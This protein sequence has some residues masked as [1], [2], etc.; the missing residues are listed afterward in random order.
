MISRATARSRDQWRSLV[1]EHEGK[2]QTSGVDDWN[3]LVG[4]AL[5][6]LDPDPGRSR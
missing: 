2:V 3:D 4:L 6:E 1:L 5:L